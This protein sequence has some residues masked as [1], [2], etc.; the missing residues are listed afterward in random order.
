MLPYFVYTGEIQSLCQLIGINIDGSASIDKYACIY[1]L[2][3]YPLPRITSYNLNPESDPLIP[4][5]KV[6]DYLTLILNG[7]SYNKAIN[8]LNIVR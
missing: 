6:L 3:C 5:E 4:P 7:Y 8:E 2:D 1:Q